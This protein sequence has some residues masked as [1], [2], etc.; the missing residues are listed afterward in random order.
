MGSKGR[1]KEGDGQLS[2]N[3]LAG[4][5]A[6]RDVRVVLFTFDISIY[7]TNNTSDSDSAPAVSQR[8]PDWQSIVEL[9]WPAVNSIKPRKKKQ[10]K[11]NPIAVA[12]PISSGTDRQ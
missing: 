8:I 3:G 11:A 2:K 7:S 6:E 4:G 10:E 1:E 12:A 5:Y 9:A